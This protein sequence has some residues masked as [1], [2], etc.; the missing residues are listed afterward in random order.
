M[1][2]N[3]TEQMMI[4]YLQQKLDEFQ[5]VKE[6]GIDD[7][8]VRELFDDMISCKEMAEAIIQW[9]VNLQ[10]DGKVTVGF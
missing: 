1:E 6:K 5:S 8:M 2:L 9:P 10:K 4:N 3:K 7:P